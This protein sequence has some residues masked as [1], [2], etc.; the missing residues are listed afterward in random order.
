ML[1][2][3]VHDVLLALVIALALVLLI[4]CGNVSNLLIARCLGR[5]QEFAVRSA[6]GAGQFRLVRQLLLKAGY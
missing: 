1:T 6:L 5:Q 3:S 4:A 2:S